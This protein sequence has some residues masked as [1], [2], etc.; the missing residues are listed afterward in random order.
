[1]GGGRHN[2][3][4][5]MSAPHHEIEPDPITKSL[6]PAPRTQ[7]ERL[8]SN[9]RRQSQRVYSPSPLTARARSQDSEE[10]AA[11]YPTCRLRRDDRWDYLGRAV[12]QG[13][14]LRQRLET[15]EGVVLDLTDALARD[16]ERLSNL[17]E[18]TWLVPIEPEA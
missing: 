1:M 2:R 3:A 15:P 10:P 7:W 13:L 17:F 16:T 6:R 9:Q 5:V 8:D 14:S 11:S 12:A 18:R 4:D